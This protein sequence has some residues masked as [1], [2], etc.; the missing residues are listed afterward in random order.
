MYRWGGCCYL[1]L[2]SM[3]ANSPVLVNTVFGKPANECMAG[4]TS[5]SGLLANM[6][7]Q[8]VLDGHWAE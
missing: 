2:V 1:V 6:T 4:R 7:A 3:K 5:N 8:W